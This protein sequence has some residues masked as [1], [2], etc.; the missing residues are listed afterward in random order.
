[1]LRQSHSVFCYQR[2]FHIMPLP[3]FQFSSFPVLPSSCYSSC[4][5]LQSPQHTVAVY[6]QKKASFVRHLHCGGVRDC[7]II[8]WD[9]YFF[10]PLGCLRFRW[11]VQW[12]ILF[13]FYI[14]VGGWF[15]VIYNI[16]FILFF[17]L[18]HRSR[19]S[20]W[21]WTKKKN[22]IL[23]SCVPG[24][25]F[26]IVDMCYKFFHSAS[27]LCIIDNNIGKTNRAR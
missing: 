15:D 6:G 11:G 8:V 10:A 5:I 1:M 27:L 26:R 7:R 22:E 17:A 21:Q 19:I 24:F 20:D 25:L 9:A 12:R 13:S 16:F 18:N 3:M 14:S 2:H 23:L 4:S